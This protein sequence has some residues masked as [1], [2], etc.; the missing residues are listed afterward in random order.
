[1]YTGGVLQVTADLKNLAA[2]RT[3][4]ENQVAALGADPNVVSDLALA[5]DE[6]VTNVIVH[7]YGG[8]PGVIEI[9]VR[10]EG[11]D[12][13]VLVRDSAPPFDP[14]NVSPPDL[15]APLEERQP[16]GLGIFLVRQFTDQVL[17][18]PTPQGG[19]ELILKRKIAREVAKHESD[20]DSN[21][22]AGAG[23][24]SGCAG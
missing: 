21:A 9:E 17:Y 8:N 15:N 5:A 11:A 7:G 18:C 2:M 3:F 19:N 6:V 13:I 12:A 24:C 4:V 22:R 10:Q 20:S 23:D 16:G 1:M 14:T